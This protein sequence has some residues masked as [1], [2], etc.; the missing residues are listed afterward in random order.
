MEPIG[1]LETS[2]TNYQ[3]ARLKIPEERRSHLHR[4][5]RLKLYYGAVFEVKSVVFRGLSFLD[6]LYEILEP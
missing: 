3:S 4:G 5:R 6:S 2:A 1:C